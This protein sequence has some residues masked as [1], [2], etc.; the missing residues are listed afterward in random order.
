MSEQPGLTA[1]FV[2][3]TVERYYA[4]MQ[5]M[6]KEDDTCGDEYPFLTEIRIKGKLASLSG[7][8]SKVQ[9]EQQ[10][11]AKKAKVGS[12]SDADTEKLGQ[13][14]KQLLIIAENMA[15]WR[16]LRIDDI[17]V[18]I[19]FLC[20][21]GYKGPFLLCLRGLAAKLDGDFE[22]AEDLLRRYFAESP[23][24][25]HYL[26]NKYL[27]MLCAAQSKWHQVKRHAMRA[28]A[29]KPE[30]IEL[31]HLMKTAHQELREINFVIQEQNIINLLMGA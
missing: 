10:F 24:S 23:D 30:D 16:S 13:L 2:I 18:S 1:S 11:I 25:M 28:I 15:Y 21:I 5:D 12:L 17:Q 14:Q 6:A 7:E 3:K 19:Q 4:T 26:A 31:H 27:A 20:D 8:F 29:I 9:A 22:N